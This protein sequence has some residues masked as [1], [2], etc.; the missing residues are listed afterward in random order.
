MTNEQ[1]YIK[2]LYKGYM[3]PPDKIPLI[4]SNTALAGYFFGEEGLAVV[5]FLM[6]VFFLF[7]TIGFW[8]NYG[9]FTK[10]IEAVGH[11]ETDIARSYSSIALILSIIF[12][13][14]LS[15]AVILSF[16]NLI[17]FL[18]IPEELHQM[19]NDY[20]IMMA[21]CGMI[22]VIASYCWQFVK[23]IGLQAMIRK[24]YIFIMI[25]DA[26][27]AIACIKIFNLGIV[28]LAIG[29]IGA[30]LFVILMSGLWFSKTFKK[31][32]FGEI[33][34]PVKSI[35]EIISAGSS[36]SLGKFYSLFI[37]FL[38]NILILKTIG[39][40][41]V[42]AFAT[43]QIAIRICR[44]HSQVT[45]QPIAPILTMEY[46]DRNSLSILLLFKHSLKQ[47]I[48]MAALPAIVIYFGVSLGYF[49]DP[50]DQ[51]AVE[52]FKA[53]SLSVIFAAIN[54]TFIIWYS[55]INRKMLSNVFEIL[56][57]LILILLFIKFNDPSNMFYSFLFAESI[58]LVLILLS[59]FM[60][61]KPVEESI[62]FVVDRQA[63]LTEDDRNKINDQ[64]LV[65]FISEWLKL[66]KQFSDTGKNDFTSI[67][68]TNDKITLRSTGKL[69]NYSENDQ[70][71]AIIKHFGFTNCK[72]TYTLGLN[73]LY[74]KLS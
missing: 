38:F 62:F 67:H 7:E 60:I 6:P 58:V 44:L 2:N 71:K 9:A 34:N 26:L 46:A 42:A 73:N 33:K 24:I 39:V 28:S 4:V 65:D 12:G 11:D 3:I 16:Q 10:S 69:F 66:V 21:I 41:G 32:L 27:V 35:V 64:K 61:K 15:F 13:V 52:S 55:V 20:G 59:W 18:E 57:S 72:F 14:I 22:L 40:S 30:L 53:Y 47:A 74:L 5:S 51:F 31:N 54:S 48:I 1:K 63:G 8:I 37:V 29:M 25:V 36:A 45:W 23:M 43:I 68:I 50:S 17:N 49:V 19:A 56:R 70:A